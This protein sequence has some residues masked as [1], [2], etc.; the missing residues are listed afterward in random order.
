LCANQKRVY[1]ALDGISSINKQEIPIAVSRMKSNG[2]IL[3]TSE[4]VLFELLGDATNPKFKDISKLIKETREST[5][6]AL[7]K[8]A[9]CL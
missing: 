6:D 8:L 7:S 5:A 4:S 9:P 2:C 1:I 3:T